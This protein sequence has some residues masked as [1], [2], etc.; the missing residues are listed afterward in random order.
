M[1][2][3]KMLLW[4]ALFESQRDASRSAS[5]S[6]CWNSFHTCHTLYQPLE[7]GVRLLAPEHV[8][9]KCPRER[10]VLYTSRCTFCTE[11]KWRPMR[12]PARVSNDVIARDSSAHAIGV[13]KNIQPAQYPLHF[14]QARRSGRPKCTHAPGIAA[15]LRRGQRGGDLLGSLPFESDSVLSREEKKEVW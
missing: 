9:K 1:T 14:L 15:S 5:S 3:P 8:R 12:A 6:S 2:V 11:Q 7:A 10:S 13:S 4:C